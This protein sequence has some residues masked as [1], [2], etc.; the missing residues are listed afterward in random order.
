M[1]L[2][3]SQIEGQCGEK[4]YQ[5]HDRRYTNKQQHYGQNQIEEEEKIRV[6]QNSLDKV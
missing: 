5:H 1:I 2:S 4:L 3:M 6:A